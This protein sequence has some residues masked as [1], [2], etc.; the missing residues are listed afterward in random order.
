ML[1]SKKTLSILESHI[2]K[3][4]GCKACSLS[5]G[6]PIFYR[7]T[8]PCSVMF[9]AEQPDL[10]SSRLFSPFPGSTPEG[11]ILDKI[12]SILKCHWCVTFACSCGG[13][14]GPTE[15]FQQEAC[16][17]KLAELIGMAKPAVLMSVGKVSDVYVLNNM[18]YFAEVLGY[19]PH[20]LRMNALSWFVNANSDTQSLHIKKAQLALEEALSNVRR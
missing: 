5:S 20:S 10:S 16:R 4:T 18:H 14:D 9:V 12:V 2:S 8:I 17:P 6:S 3:W 7:G 11:E 13:N 19:R 1:A 15:R